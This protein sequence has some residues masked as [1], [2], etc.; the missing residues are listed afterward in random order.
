MFCRQKKI[1]YISVTKQNNIGSNFFGMKL[2]KISTSVSP[3]AGISFVHNEF[4]KS[5]MSELID[6]ELGFSVKTVGY[7]CSDIN[8]V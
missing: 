4:V 5:E 1:T 7:L 2:Q 6:N 3:F 8:V